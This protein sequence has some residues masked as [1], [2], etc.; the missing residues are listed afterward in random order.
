M[1]ESPLPESTLTTLVDE[2]RRVGI[3]V[4][5]GEH[6]DAARALTAIPLA[7]REVVRASL[8][9]AMVKRAEQLDAFNLL[10]DLHFG[11][12]GATGP[13]SLAALSADEL[14]AALRSA[15]ELADAAQL[16]ALAAE[17]VRRYAKIG[18]A[19]V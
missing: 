4:S 7:D 9:C 2:L 5:V 19:H 1:P 18:R 14:E 6:L 15:L 13:P 17:Y 8:Q 12:T 16:R 10:F 11:G 3:G